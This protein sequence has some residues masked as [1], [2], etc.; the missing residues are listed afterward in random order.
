MPLVTRLQVPHP[1][2]LVDIRQCDSSDSD[3]VLGKDLF[4]PL[5][6]SEILPDCEKTLARDVELLPFSEAAVLPNALDLCSVVPDD[7]ASLDVVRYDPHHSG[8]DDSHLGGDPLHAV[9]HSIH[10]IQ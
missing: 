4:A 10:A 7:S 2:P 1:I 3:S 9:V 8:V 5:I 6:K